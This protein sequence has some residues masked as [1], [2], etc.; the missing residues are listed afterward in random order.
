MDTFKFKITL[1]RHNGTKNL[2]FYDLPDPP[3]FLLPSTFNV[4]VIAY[5]FDG[6]GLPIAILYYLAL[7]PTS[8]KVDGNEK[9]GGS[10][11]T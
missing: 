5:H 6:L 8:L 11:R 10:G 7:S 3:H 1:D 4:K 9:R 2:N